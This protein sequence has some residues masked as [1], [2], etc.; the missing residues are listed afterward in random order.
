MRALE[1][2]PAAR[3]SDAD[4]FSHALEEARAT[5]ADGAGGPGHGQLRGGPAPRRSSTR[6]RGGRSGTER[7]PWFALGLTALLLVLAAV[8]LLGGDEKVTC[9]LSRDSRSPWPANACERR[10]LRGRGRTAAGPRGGGQVIDQDPNGG[11]KAD[12]GSTVTLIVSSGPGSIRSHRRH[13]GEAGHQGADPRRLRRPQVG[14]P[15]RLQ[16]RR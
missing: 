10:G 3:W 12:E 16:G 11:T 6:S 15:V 2:D 13:V 7:W 8:L 5:L 4:E 1:K 14:R 9:R